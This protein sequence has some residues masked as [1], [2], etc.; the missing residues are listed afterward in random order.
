MRI[1]QISSARS[2]GG[3][4]RHVIDLSNEFTKRGHDIFAAVVPGSPMPKALSRLPRENIAEFPL[5]NALDISTAVRIAR[6]ASQNKIE[7]INAHF[8]KDYPV[9]AVAARIAGVP[10]VITRHVLFPMNRLHRVFLRDV[11]YVIAPSNAA[12]ES[13]RKQQLFPSEK[14]V[15][16]RY[17]LE[18][19]KFPVRDAFD[20]EGFVIGAIGNLDPVKGFDVLVR[21]ARTVIDK[22]PNARFEIV[23][24]DRSR[25]GHNEIE[26]RK[27][28]AELDLDQAVLLKGWSDDVR[29]VLAGFDLFIS[30]SRSE[31]F[32][33]VIAEAM[34]SGVP[35]IATETEGAKEIISDPSL[36][37][38]V[39][40]GSTEPLADVILQLTTDRS[41]RDA[42]AS[43][44]RAHI[45]R[46]FSMTRMVDETEALYRRAVSE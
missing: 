26:L 33:F 45:E 10:F 8:A 4:E 13:L 36:G 28:I 29:E 35:V 42:L 41:Q 18:V 15:T 40:V 34:L 37:R 1:L 39:P 3:G 11:K 38:L 14:I 2:I 7:L 24:E 22:M 5:R 27:L 23:G 17:G 19:D 43:S 20:R 44:G 31:S 9:A 25:N 32:G 6:F 12:A 46:S 30:S 16:I 21:A